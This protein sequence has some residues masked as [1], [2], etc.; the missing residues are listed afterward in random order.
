MGAFDFLRRLSQPAAR[1]RGRRAVAYRGFNAAKDNR[2]VGGWLTHA[3]SI[4]ENLYS[5]L[6]S[7]RA[8]SRD[9]YLNN[10]FVR[11]FISMC[12]TNIVGPRGVV[13]QS[14][15]PS[16]RRGDMEIDTMAADAIEA[17]WAEWGRA[18][19]CDWQ[20]RF[21]WL[22]LQ[23]IAVT[24]LYCDGEILARHHD[25]PEAG[26]FGYQ[27]EMLDPE[28]LDVRYRA[29]VRGGGKIIMGIEYDRDMRAVAYHLRQRTDPT[30]SYS[31]SNGH[32]YTRIPTGE[33]IHGFNPEQVGQLR[34]YPATATAM[35]RLKMLEGY[36]DAAL[37]AARA[38]AAKMGF[39]TQPAGAEYSGD[40]VDETGTTITDFEAGIIERLAEGETFQAF[41]PAYPHEQFAAFVKT[42]LQTA[43]ISMGPGV[44]HAGL[45]GNLEGVSYSSIRSGTLEERE[46]WKGAQE[47][48]I[49]VFTRPV[50]ERWLANA[51]TMN[52]IKIGGTPLRQSDF[53]RYKVASMQPRRWAWVDPTADIEASLK[54][55][56]ANIATVS[57][58]IREMGHD[59]DDVFTERAL[60]KQKMKKLGLEEQE[61]LKEVGNG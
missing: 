40:G 23:N 29:D 41:D 58:T 36:F 28:L 5:D 43:G 49:G 33:I 27:V 10:D 4:N 12:R 15:V 53:D 46:A 24:S 42:C 47:L 2:L 60:E 7:L 30:R 59:P 44:S 3:E 11:R 38:G 55:I 17:A 56:G 20:R 31:S 16:G 57:G 22:Q 54:A 39:L 52:A 35:L 61:V 32:N 48:F 34:G 14:R 26:P 51:M 25:G 45:S 9:L 1:G 19:N 37:T 50:F 8:R 18:V 6:A 21:D 13:L